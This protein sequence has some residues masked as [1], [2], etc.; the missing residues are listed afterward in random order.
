MIILHLLQKCLNF[1]IL[2]CT[3]YF[4]ICESFC[5]CNFIHLTGRSA[6]C[7]CSHHFLHALFD[8]YRFRINFK[9]LFVN[10]KAFVVLALSKL[11]HRLA[12][13]A[14]DK[15]WLELN[16]L[17]SIFFSLWVRQKL[18]VG[19]RTIRV[20]RVITWVALDRFC[21][22]LDCIRKI[23]LLEKL[24]A[25][26]LFLCRYLRIDVL[27]TFALLKRTFGATKIVECSCSATFSERIVEALY[28][29]F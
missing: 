13:V 11:N 22:C 6:L 15:V 12:K 29:F 1:W 23:T 4:W 9:C 16:A 28:S 2:K 19:K 7:N 24:N 18:E 21:K 10:R 3:L 8:R 5:T 26:G 25:L 17:I 20:D 27:L 14:F